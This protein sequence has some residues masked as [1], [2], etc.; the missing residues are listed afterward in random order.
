MLKGGANPRLNIPLIKKL[1]EAAGV[2]LV[3]HGGSGIRDEDFT[4]AI[5]AGMSIIHINTELR[6]AYRQGIEAGLRE[7]PDEI[8]PYRFM[9]KA[10]DSMESVA[11]NRLKLFNNQ[12]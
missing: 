9:K 8:A 3:L 11:F 6:L 1:R 4:S 7:N 5:A 12:K 10:V 2:P